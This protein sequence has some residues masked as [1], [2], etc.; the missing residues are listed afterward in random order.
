MSHTHFMILCKE[1]EKIILQCKC[2][3]DGKPRYKEIC[4]RCKNKLLGFEEQNS[5]GYEDE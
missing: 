1:C 2:L 3:W 4:E 5:E